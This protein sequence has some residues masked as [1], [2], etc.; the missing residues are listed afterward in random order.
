MAVGLLL[1]GLG[2]VTALLRVAAWLGSDPLIRLSALTVVSACHVAPFLTI[3][4]AIIVSNAPRVR[5]QNRT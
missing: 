5:L 3:P 1:A 4:Q 2:R